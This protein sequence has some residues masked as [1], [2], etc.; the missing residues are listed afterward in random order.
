M[1]LFSPLL[2]LI[3][4]I[5]L[6]NGFIRFPFGQPFRIA[7][8]E[9]KKD[10]FYELPESQESILKKINGFYGLIGP[11]IDINNVTNIFDL[12]TGD[13]VIQ[14]IFFD[15]GEL[16]FVKKFVRTDKLLYE[17]ENGRIPNHN[18]FKILFG[19]FNKV[20]A[21]PDLLGLANTALLQIN[22]KTYALYERDLPY[23]IDINFENKTI[24]TV[25]R[26]QICGISHVS[27]HTKFNKE[28]N[29][30]ETID[31]DITSNSVKYLELTP[32]LYIK[33]SKSIKLDY[34]PVIHDFW[35]TDNR[36]VLFDSP[37]QVELTKI[38][39]NPMPVFLNPKKNTMIHILDKQ[40][41]T[42]EKYDMGTSA[43]L[44]HFANSKE[45]NTHIDIYASFYD[46]LDFS[47]LNIKGKYRKVSINKVTKQVSIQKNRIFE[48]MDIEFPI[49]YKN[50]TIFRSIKNKINNGFV[51]CEDLHI[52]ARIQFTDRFIAGEPAIVTIDGVGQMIS[53]CFH[54]DN[55]R[56]G[57]LLIIN[58]DTYEQIEI[59]LLDSINLGFHSI[60]LP[61]SDNSTLEP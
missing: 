61:N 21:L 25:G 22:K 38:I 13:G 15:N 27:A 12:F 19:L 18:V 45:N 52:R 6:I 57:Y 55:N 11:D 37:L 30:I 3:V 58:L 48:N 10:I 23:E 34:L 7:N 29:I 53:F 2:I 8:R 9:I 41:M 4:G 32:D 60:F 28:K 31:Y 26:K 20:N 44:F 36:V 40:T 35:T 46:S 16:T 54:K 43:Y 14:G 59:P 56:C 24:E 50:C 1:H 39:I 42:V 33:R 17:E 47:D 5:P 51:I 49:L